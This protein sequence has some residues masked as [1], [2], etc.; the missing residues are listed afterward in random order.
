[1]TASKRQTVRLLDVSIILTVL[2]N[3]SQAW[4]VSQQG[5]L[6]PAETCT[7]ACPPAIPNQCGLTASAVWPACAT[8]ETGCCQYAC[9]TWRLT[10]TAPECQN[11]TWV[12]FSLTGVLPNG[13][14]GHGQCIVPEPPS[15]EPP[16]VIVR[17]R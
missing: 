13:V 5:A 12:R 2:F 4:V 3:V 17:Y 7:G 15:P 11:V 14:C 16:P 1:M 10:G 8:R 6:C 9:R